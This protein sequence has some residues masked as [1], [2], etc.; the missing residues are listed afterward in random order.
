[1][2]CSAL[3]S[4]S[5]AAHSL[6][7]AQDGAAAILAEGFAL[8]ILLLIGLWVVTHRKNWR[9]CVAGFAAALGALSLG[10]AA[11]LPEA[12]PDRTESPGGRIAVLLDLS[13]SVRRDGEGRWN[14]A[15]NRLAARIESVAPTLEG[16]W[17]G[18]V[19]G[20][21]ATGA[22]LS[23]ELNLGSLAASV[24]A[25]S[26]GPVAMR[27]NLASGLAS[28]M[29]WIEAGPGG[30]AVYLMSD[31]WADGTDPMI[32]A[33]R[34]AGRGVPVHVLPLGSEQSGQGLLSWNLG[35]EQFTGQET[36]A[37]L[38]ILGNGRL[39]W[40]IDGREGAPLDVPASDDPRAV[41]LPVTFVSRGIAHVALGFGN[42]S[43]VR[44]SATLYTLVRGPARVLVYGTAAWV[45]ALSPDRYS[46]QRAS[47][48]AEVPAAGY[49][50]VVIDA[51]S[52]SNFPEGF[53]GRLLGAMA[54]GTGLLIENGPR[55]EPV[56]EPQRIAD[57]EDSE[58]GPLLPV[59]SD[60]AIY[61]AEPP[62]RNTL[63]IIDTSGSMVDGNF[64]RPAIEVARRIL[65]F[66]RPE[67]RVTILPF[68]TVVGPR[69]ASD[70]LT[71]GEH[72]RAQAYLEGLR[73]EGATN[74]NLAVNAAAQL[75]GASCD[76]FVIG[77]GDYPSDRVRVNPNCQTT[78][79]GVAG[80]ELPGFDTSYGEALVLR[81]GQNIGAMTF[82]T[83]APQPRT[84]FWSDGPH[85]P[86]VDNA[87]A[88]IRFATPIPG[89][90]LTYPRPNAQIAAVATQ[91]PRPLVLAYR[92]DPRQ[93]SI[94]TAVFLGEMPDR[95][96]ADSADAILARLVAWSDP[97][98]YDIAL[99]QDGD[100]IEIR[101][102]V[103]EGRP[104]PQ[105]LSGS[106]QFPDGR[107]QGLNLRPSDVPGEFLG[108]FEIHRQD[109]VQRALLTLEES[110]QSVQTIPVTFP[111]RGVV[112]SMNS[113]PEAERESRGV[114][115]PLLRL[116]ANA[117]GGFNLAQATPG[118][119]NA[120]AEEPSV[121][122]WPLFC[123]LGLALF[124]L[125]L[126]LGGSRR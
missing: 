8:A 62:P 95:L 12:V 87:F 32:E 47:P 68:G 122:L 42:D 13:E 109:V 39:T 76:L 31:G 14:A 61:F 63:I 114:N 21:G 35:P 41:R 1:M 79:I 97:E 27:S 65:S 29:A 70:G 110:P 59:N 51:L 84:T 96:P 53:A 78:T 100:A 83:H 49:D 16:P 90:A 37:R 108:R 82:Q 40:S 10:I 50:A 57:W 77:D 33:R 25:A 38:N 116:L 23:S 86:L 44:Q 117:T 7:C 99:D 74:I 119:V 45:D 94:S 92:R 89:L 64:V 112:S 71:A 58:L 4:L 48:G 15:R 73:W 26:P 107:S 85:V 101:V 118:Y 105:V 66:Q 93:Q 19:F 124:T 111:S 88:P 75:R 102:S 123:T 34:A 22:P 103:T 98:R 54:G 2:I 106:V 115:E 81:R 28:T 46:V 24:R 11:G 9:F 91:A 72:A 104:T 6:H 126:W 121:P 43:P 80:I 20:F 67:D 120:A 60:P 125:N 52:P 55:R 17:T 113:F 30:G 69:F 3:E 5:L 18:R 56:S 36:V